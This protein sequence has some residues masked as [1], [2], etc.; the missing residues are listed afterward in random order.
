MR[1]QQSRDADARR[2]APEHV[3]RGKPY[4]TPRLLEYGDLRKITTASKGADMDDGG[5]APVTRK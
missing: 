4:R 3:K 5:G 1:K 2:V